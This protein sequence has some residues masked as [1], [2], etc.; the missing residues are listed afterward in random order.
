[1]GRGGRGDPEANGWV[2]GTMGLSQGG[3]QQRS[4]PEGPGIPS[5][6]A[7]LFAEARGKAQVRFDGLSGC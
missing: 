1:M 5:W 3:G 7:W 4:G 6:G 2:V